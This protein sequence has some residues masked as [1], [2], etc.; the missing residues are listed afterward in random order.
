MNYVRKI[1]TLLNEKGIPFAVFINPLNRDVVAALQGIK[2]HRQFLSWKQEMKSIFPDIYDYSIS[3]YS[4]REGLCGGSFS[5]H[6]RHGN[7]VFK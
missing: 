2:A 6:Q 5:L 4:A 3:R 1:K 7:S